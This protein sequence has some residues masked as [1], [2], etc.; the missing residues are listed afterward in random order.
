MKLPVINSER[1]L[2]LEDLPGEEW[3]TIPGHKGAYQVSTMGRV[4]CVGYTMKRRRR[5]GVTFE[6]RKTPFIKVSK[7]NGHGYY[8][9]V[10]EGHHYYVHRLVAQAFVPNMFEKP[11][12]DHINGIRFDNRAD[13]LR[14]V[15]PLENVRNRSTLGKIIAGGMKKRKG[16]YQIDP[17]SGKIVREWSG[18]M[19]AAENLGISRVV[20]GECANSNGGG[21]TA[22]GYVFVFTKDYDPQ[23]DYRVFRHRSG[24]GVNMRSVVEYKSGSVYRVF[25]SVVSAASNFCCSISAITKI[26]REG[27]EKKKVGRKQTIPCE[28]LVYLKDAPI[29]DQDRILRGESYIFI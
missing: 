26:C 3:A 5:D 25:G 21:R 13:N 22:A 9:I 11:D 17:K 15:T 4:K 14:W 28:L 29:E 27:R 19:E 16:I 12:I 24:N 20:I 7:D 23:K 18:I 10:V 8:T 2:S 1:W 6:Y